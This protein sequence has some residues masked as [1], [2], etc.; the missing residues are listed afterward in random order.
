VSPCELASGVQPSIPDGIP[1]A[2]QQEMPFREGARD[3]KLKRNTRDFLEKRML[4]FNTA[5]EHLAKAQELQ[6][7]CHNQTTML[8]H[9][10]V[11]NIVLLSAKN[12][13]TRQPYRKLDS[14]WFGPFEIK[15][16][17]GMQAYEL[18][19]PLGM[20]RL[21][22]TFH[23]S[24]L[25]PYHARPGYNPGP[26]PML[27][28]EGEHDETDITSRDHYEIEKIVTYQHDREGTLFRGRWL[29]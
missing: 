27:L 1:D 4:D 11:G 14:K 2:I 3:E 19:L 6:R 7:K 20:Q 9:F 16:R 18:M 26:V 23:V 10:E 24:L 25:K 12:I 13:H 29:G 8:K 21:H 15:S 22:P 17:K 28:E 5:R